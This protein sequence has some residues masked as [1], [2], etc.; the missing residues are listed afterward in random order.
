MAE[1]TTK[2]LKPDLDETINVSEVHAGVVDSSAAADREKALR[3]N[4]MESV[5]LIVF[6]IAG[7]VIVVAGFVMG[8]AGGFMN[9]DQLSKDG[10]VRGASGVDEPEEVKPVTRLSFIKSKGQLAYGKCIACHQSEGQG[11]SGIPPLAG[12]EW[13]TGNT[14]RLLMIIHN[15]VKGP[16]TVAGKEYNDN[17]A[18][19]GAGFDADTMA[20]LMTY[21]RKSWGNDASVVTKEMAEAGLKISK[22]RGGAQTTAAELMA[23]HDKMLPGEGIN[24]EEM[25]HPFTGEVWTEEE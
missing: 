22:D 20:A 4:G 21:I 18:A 9:Y 15:G 14:E 8:K 10:Y 7:F 23:N 17:M 5:S 25:V 12:S 2:D 11:G 6:L 13:V 19:L 1:T 24:E 16:I 3:E